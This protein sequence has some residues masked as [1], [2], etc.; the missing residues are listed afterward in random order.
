M[1]GILSGAILAF[2][3]SLGEFGATIIFAGNIAGETQTLPLAIYTLMQ[4]PGAEQATLRLV[5][6]SAGISLLAMFVSEWYLK[7]LKHDRG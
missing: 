2:A 3:R 1:P 6:V 7:K 5:L 4:V